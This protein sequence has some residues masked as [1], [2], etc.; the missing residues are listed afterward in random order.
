MTHI[1]VKDGRVAVSGGRV[2]TSAGGAPCCC[3]GGACYIIMLACGCDDL[4]QALYTPVGSAIDL[5]WPYAD[6][7]AGRAISVNGVCY[8]YIGSTTTVPPFADL[9]SGA[10]GTVYD[11]CDDSP[12]SD[13]AAC[14]PCPGG[15]VA[16]MGNGVA[17]P[18]RFVW[19]CVQPFRIECIASIEVVYSATA[20]ARHIQIYSGR[21][22][23]EY[24]A[25]LAVDFTA[26]FVS[27]GE[28]SDYSVTE[29]SVGYYRR[30]H[31]T[32]GDLTDEDVWDYQGTHT[33]G[34]STGA[35]YA[36]SVSQS[37]LPGVGVFGA[38]GSDITNGFG[39]GVPDSSVTLLQVPFV[40]NGSF[41][42]TTTTGDGVTDTETSSSSVSHS[43]AASSV[44]VTSRNFSTDGDDFYDLE[45][46]TDMQVTR[47][48][49]L[50]DGTVIEQ[51]PCDAP[52]SRVAVACDPQA[53]PQEITYDPSTMPASAVSMVDTATGLRYLPTNT[54]STGSPITVVYEGEGCPEPPAD[55]WPVAQECNG[56]RTLTFD[57]ALRP[58]DGVSFVVG[59][60]RYRVT[61]LV[62]EELPTP[63]TWSPDPCPSNPCGGLLPNDP[64]CA[65][66]EF[67]D[68]PQ[69]VG[70]DIGDPQPEPDFD[71]Q[72]DGTIPGLGD[73]V[74]EAIRTIS[75][76]TILPCSAC[77]RRKQVLN[78]FGERAGRAVIRLL[79]W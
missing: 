30:Y 78:R 3:G 22:R 21:T 19:E 35:L 18:I 15:F 4:R 47:R 38:S 25:R 12:C 33:T 49:T 64:R 48:I 10:A 27:P 58:A 1:I 45:W 77:E 46:A 36:E 67:R 26:T 8:R 76:N 79:R 57:P 29:S 71:L 32:T 63:G 43:P 16:S 2:V 54:P 59:P 41:N 44:S 52:S 51:S 24:E 20:S 70:F 23:Y 68:C 13:Q 17:F 5:A 37:L 34:I 56:T 39:Y 75:L 11:S 53:D 28:A 72:D 55:V 6:R 7:L 9:L 66:P 60:V 31:A 50:V 73:M 74:A 40:C 14:P 61:N 69:C 62:R 42:E 65:L